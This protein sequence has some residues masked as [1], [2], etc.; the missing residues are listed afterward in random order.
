MRNTP[1]GLRIGHCCRAA[2]VPRGSRSAPEDAP[3][4]PRCALAR[5]AG[6]VALDG[7]EGPARHP[8]ARNAV[9]RGRGAAGTA[10]GCGEPWAPPRGG[11]DQGHS[12]A[13]CPVSVPS[14]P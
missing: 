10:R 12:A 9:P 13:P 5:A 1:A 2:P 3:V 4:P 8:S 7:T 6:K 11:H 14:M